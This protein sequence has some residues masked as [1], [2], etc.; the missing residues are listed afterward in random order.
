MAT[1]ADFGAVSETTGRRESASCPDVPGP[2]GKPRGK[3][4]EDGSPTAPST[5]MDE[6]ASPPPAEAAE[7]ADGAAADG[8]R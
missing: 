3:K 1:V 6:L 4:P 7:A 2:L 5:S 8:T